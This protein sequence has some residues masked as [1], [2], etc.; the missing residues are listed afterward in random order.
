[1]PCSIPH[2]KKWL[3]RP[4]EKAALCAVRAV[5]TLVL[6]WARQCRKSTTLGAIAFDE[7]SRA[8]GRRVIAASASLLLGSELVSKSV[9]ALEHAATVAREAAALQRALLSSLAQS[10]N[11]LSLVAANSE[12]GAEYPSLTADDF[13]ALYRAGRLEIPLP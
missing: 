13:T 6:L 7:M 8:P 12:T 2:P 4:Y 3:R 9:T 5:R 10:E 1:M 11:P